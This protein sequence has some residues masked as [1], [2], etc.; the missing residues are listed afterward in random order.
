MIA[1]NTTTGSPSIQGDTVHL[2][3]Y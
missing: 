2:A 1:V 3:R